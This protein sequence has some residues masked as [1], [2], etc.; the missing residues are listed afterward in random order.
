[1]DDIRA[2]CI[3]GPRGNEI[4]ISGIPR[5]GNK[6]AFTAKCVVLDAPSRYE[7]NP[8]N[9]LTVQLAGDELLAFMKS[10]ED[11]LQGCV[12]DAE[13]R[14]SAKSNIF[15][16]TFIRA[17]VSDFLR[18]WEGET[19]TDEGFP[20]PGSEVLVMGTAKPYI[21]AGKWGI[22]ATIFQIQTI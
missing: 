13:Q 2:E 15:G 22:T 3:R 8:K 18:V 21:M 6:I 10:L 9:A 12:K 19:R 7:D 17:K 11:L 16:E 14:E 1:L 20:K 4:S 5:F